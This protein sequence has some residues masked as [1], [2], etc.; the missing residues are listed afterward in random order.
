MYLYNSQFSFIVEFSANIAM[1]PKWDT[2]HKL[3]KAKI[4]Q[5]FHVDWAPLR[6]RLRGGN[7]QRS[8]LDR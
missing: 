8:P 1:F 3:V 4:S 2:R 7:L 5:N 6:P